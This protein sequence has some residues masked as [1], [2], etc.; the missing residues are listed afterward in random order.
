MGASNDGVTV[1]LKTYLHTEGACRPQ[2][3]EALI[4]EVPPTYSLSPV[5]AALQRPSLSLSTLA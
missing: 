3:P 1:F 4:A 5:P 2:G